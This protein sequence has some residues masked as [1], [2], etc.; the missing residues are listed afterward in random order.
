MTPKVEGLSGESGDDSSSGGSS[1]RRLAK[2]TD[3]YRR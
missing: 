1:S 2:N 3:E